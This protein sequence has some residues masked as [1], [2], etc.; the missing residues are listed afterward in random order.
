MATLQRK[1]EYRFFEKRVSPGRPVQQFINELDLVLQK[2][3]N[4]KLFSSQKLGRPTIKKKTNYGRLIKRL[5]YKLKST[6]TV[7][8]KTDKSKVFHLGRLEDYQKRS[9]EYMD[10]TKAYHCLGDQNPLPDLIKRTNQY[11]LQLRLAKWITQKQYEQL[12]VNPT[13]V[14]LAHLYYL[15]KS[16][17]P[18]TPLRPII[19]GIKYPTMKI[20]QFLDS[21]L[22]PLFDQMSIQTTVDCGFELI[23]LLE[24]WSETNFKKETVLGTI[25]VADLYTMIP[26]I[27]GVLALR[28]MFDYLNIKQIDGL[29][30]EIIIRLARFVMVNNYFKYNGQY[31]HQTRGGAMGSPLTLT[32][33]NCYMFFFERNIVKQVNNSQGLYIRYIDDIFVIINWP[34]RHLTKQVDR[35]KNSISIFVYLRTLVQVQISSIYTW[36][37]RTA[38]Y[39]HPCIT[40]PRTNPTICHSTAFI[41]YI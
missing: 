8:R 18:G 20:S 35:W 13:K 41:R 21:L 6:N 40:N 9:D 28:K 29:K 27:E 22:R 14:E 30:V 37:I 2:L 1:I 3:H 34:L 25:D 7:L 12:C 15:P 17:K 11:L 10:K 5:R 33:A 23:R 31:Y 16:H 32:I 26:Q 4:T 24:K 38:N 36:K 39:I 19:S